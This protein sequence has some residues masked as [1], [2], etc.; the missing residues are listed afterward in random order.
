MFVRMCK[1]VCVTRC[2]LVPN[3]TQ[4]TKAAAPVTHTI[5]THITTTL[6]HTDTQ[7]IHKTHTHAQAMAERIRIEGGPG[8]G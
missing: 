2:V 7:D 3:R 4:V 5:H 1:C 6:T 8:I